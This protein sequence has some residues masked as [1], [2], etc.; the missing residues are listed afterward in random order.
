MYIYFVER[1]WMLPCL[2]FPPFTA[3][4]IHVLVAAGNT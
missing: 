1:E 3:F 4:H 2:A